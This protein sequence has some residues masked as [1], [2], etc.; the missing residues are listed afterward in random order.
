MKVH[1]S[2]PSI[3]Q[4]QELD[5]LLGVGVG[6]SSDHITAVN[7]DCSNDLLSDWNSAIDCIGNTVT[8]YR[9]HCVPQD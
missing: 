2:P 7:W 1:T 4:P 6:H 5:V 3:H 9:F 8:D